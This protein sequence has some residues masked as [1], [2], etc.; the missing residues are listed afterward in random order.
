MNTQSFWMLQI[1]AS[2]LMYRQILDEI[3]ANDCKNFTKWAYASKTKKIVS[4]PFAYAKSL[5]IPSPR[6]PSPSTKT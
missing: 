6:V 3:E 1:S 2:L 4:L 5:I